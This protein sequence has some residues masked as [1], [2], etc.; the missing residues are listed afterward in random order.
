MFANRIHKWQAPALPQTAPGK[1]APVGFAV[2]PEFLLAQTADW[3]Q[4]LYRSAYERACAAVAI[5][6]HHRRFFSVWN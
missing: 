6:R 4:Q 5:P 2:A 3:Q 1:T